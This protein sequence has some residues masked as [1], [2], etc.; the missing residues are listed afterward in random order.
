MN[1]KNIDPVPLK[2]F[3]E[4]LR[5]KIKNKATPWPK[6]VPQLLQPSLP[7][8]IASHEVFA[9]FINHSTVLLQ[10]EKV[11]VLT[12]PIFS[13]AAGPFSLIGPRRVRPPGLP[14]EAVPKIDIVLLS[15]NHYDHL[16][17]ASVKQ[18]WQRDQPLFIAPLGN[19]KLLRS[20]GVQKIIELDWWQEHRLNDDYS[21]ILTPA[22]HWSRRG[23][24]DYCKSLW[25]GFILKANTLQVFFAG[26]TAYG[27][28]FKTIREK[29]GSLDFCLL[30]IGAYEPR[31]FM[32]DIHMNPADA[33]QAHLDL[34]S[35]MSMGIHFGT[36]QLTDEGI[37]DPVRQLQESLQARKVTEFIA[38]DH[39][40]TV[41]YK[42][43][44][45][46]RLLQRFSITNTPL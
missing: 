43:T 35:K 41:H 42:K 21:F 15:H 30:P 12:D 20:L 2:G 6:K 27:S 37:D 31:W 22:Q 40:Q 36:F 7:A 17:A 9:T 46:K 13:E 28:H 24:W 11:S 26:D 18:L 44:F 38:P 1:F 34:E 19:G 33:V 32:K 25:G 45:Q 10:C 16:D 4:F 14:F 29:Y 39:G 8:Q 3:G 23:L 5:W